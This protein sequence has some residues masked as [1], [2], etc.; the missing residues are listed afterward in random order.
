MVK[1]RENQ[2]MQNSKRSLEDGGRRV[3]N[4]EREKKER[5]NL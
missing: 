2:M 5:K 3:N 1:Q 4:K